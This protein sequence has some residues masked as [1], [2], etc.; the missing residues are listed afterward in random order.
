MSKLEGLFQDLKEADQKD[1]EALTV[2]QEK[3]QAI[4]SGLLAGPAGGEAATL[5]DQLMG[6]I[7]TYS[8]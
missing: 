6:N 7:S 2:A 3:F 1:S 8:F 5:Q 4:S